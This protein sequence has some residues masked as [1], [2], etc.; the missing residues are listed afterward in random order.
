M[1]EEGRKD[2]C[3]GINDKGTSTTDNYNSA[4]TQ[5]AASNKYAIQ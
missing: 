4:V 5:N 3:R 1:R 2:T